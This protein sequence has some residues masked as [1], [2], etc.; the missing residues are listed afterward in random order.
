M[1][2]LLFALILVTIWTQAKAEGTYHNSDPAVVTTNSIESPVVTS[3]DGNYGHMALASS[4]LVF[5]CCRPDTMQWAGA[6]S[7]SEGGDQSIAGGIAINFGPVLVNGRIMAV[8]DSADKANDYAAV[9]G[10]SGAFK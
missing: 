8:L 2:F 10:I 1:R 6:V 4:G 5:G 9:V 7:F 3:A